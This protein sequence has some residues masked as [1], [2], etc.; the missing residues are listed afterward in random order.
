MYKRFVSTLEFAMT[1]RLEEV[2]PS[3]FEILLLFCVNEKFW[4]I[5]EVKKLLKG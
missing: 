3:I 1:N 2:L 5:D 4:S